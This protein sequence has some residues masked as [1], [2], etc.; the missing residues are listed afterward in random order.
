MIHYDSCDMKGDPWLLLL[1]QIPPRPAY[2]R[3]QA[4]RRLAQVGAL[5]VKN[6]AYLLPDTAEALEDFQWIYQEITEQGGNAWLFRTE[7]LAGCTGEQIQQLF[8]NLREVDYQKLIE[9]ARALLEAGAPEP[10]DGI[11]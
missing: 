7:L 5:P 9:E 2:G 11:R 4:L 6:S 10:P 8:R 3:A 1:H